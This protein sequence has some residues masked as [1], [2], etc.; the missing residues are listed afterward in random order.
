MRYTEFTAFRHMDPS[1]GKSSAIA[2]ARELARFG[3]A[4]YPVLRLAFARI[5]AT[6]QPGVDRPMDSVEN[7]LEPVSNVRAVT[8]PREA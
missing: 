2:L 4:V 3:C 6:N 8:P 5:A 1:T 7:R